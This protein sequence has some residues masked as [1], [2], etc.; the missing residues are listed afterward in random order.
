MKKLLASAAVAVALGSGA[1]A[2]ST[3][4]PAGA[5]S[6]PG[7]TSAGPGGGRGERVK[8]ALDALVADGTITQ[9]QED[10]VIAALKDAAPKGGGFARGTK[11]LKEATATTATTLNMTVDELKAELKAGKSVADVASDKGVPLDTLTQALTDAATTRIDQAVADGKVT[12]D[13][14]AELK[15]ALPDLID[16]FEHGTL[17]RFRGHHRGSQGS[18]DP[19]GSTSS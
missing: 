3:V 10:K 4:L 6:G 14:A 12:A 18:E 11:A 15:A 19:S 8:G 5:Q 1:F 2:L 16:K 9:D 13:K 7:G 17:P